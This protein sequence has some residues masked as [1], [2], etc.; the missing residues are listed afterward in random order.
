[1]IASFNRFV[2]IK[3]LSILTDVVGPA[4]RHAAGVEASKGIGK[5]LFRVTEDWIVQIQALC[6]VSVLFDRVDTGSEVGDIEIT[7][8]LTALTER[9]AFFCSAT[10]ESFGIPSND[11]R[12]PSL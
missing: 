4:I 2:D 5:L 7:N 3:N 12:L 9:F 10:S 6:E 8:Q 11:E 1:M